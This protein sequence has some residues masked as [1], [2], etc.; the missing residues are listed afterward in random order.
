MKQFQV[1]PF[2]GP[3]DSLALAQ[4]KLETSEAIARRRNPD[5]AKRERD[6]CIVSSFKMWTEKLTTEDTAPAEIRAAARVGPGNSGAL[7]SSAYSV[8][9]L[10]LRSFREDGWKDFQSEISN[11]K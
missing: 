9:N 11:L 3:F 10:S 4:G 5:P 1:E 7:R 2:C 6:L 8:V